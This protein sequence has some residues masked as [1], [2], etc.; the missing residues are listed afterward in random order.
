M[1]CMLKQQRSMPLF[2]G[3]VVSFPLVYI[4]MEMYWFII[5]IYLPCQMIVMILV[6][7]LLN[8]F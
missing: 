7:S 8:G 2:I 5:I 6:P 4:A 3:S 1:S